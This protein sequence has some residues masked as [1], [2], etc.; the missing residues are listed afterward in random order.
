[1]GFTKRAGGAGKFIRFKEGK[2]ISRID[3]VDGVHDAFFG[4]LI[5]IDIEDDEYEGN[6]YRKVT[7]FM[8]DP[9]DGKLKELSFNLASGYGNAFSC[10]IGN[11][12]FSL[13]MEISGKSE[14]NDTG[15]TRTGMFISQPNVSGKMISIKWFFTKE[16]EVKMKR[17][18][19]IV[20]EKKVGGKMKKQFDFTARNAFYEAC[21]LKLRA[22]LVKITGGAASH[23]DK[24]I[25]KADVTD[26]YGGPESDFPF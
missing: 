16:N 13:P 7:L 9:D 23:K 10:I 2:L 17:P 3:G 22:N 6:E 5:D 11:V 15:G 18:Q 14:K 24:P 8:E 25:S 21:I 26:V 1:M 20:T 19:P 4:S 12:D